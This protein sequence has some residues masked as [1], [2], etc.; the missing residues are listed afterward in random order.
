MLRLECTFDGKLRKPRK[1]TKTFLLLDAT[2]RVG[3]KINAKK[4][5]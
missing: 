5:D 2:N 1:Q 3:L 4:T